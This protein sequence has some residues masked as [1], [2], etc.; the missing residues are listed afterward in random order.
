MLHKRLFSKRVS[1]KL[2]S[3]ANLLV[4]I[5]FKTAL[6]LQAISRPP[7]V[8]K[9]ITKKINALEILMYLVKFLH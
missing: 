8:E 7:T 1:Q 3:F 2:N 4:R 9:Y 6:V 5:A